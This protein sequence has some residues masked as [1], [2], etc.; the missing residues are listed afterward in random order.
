MNFARF[1]VYVEIIHGLRSPHISMLHGESSATYLVVDSG[2]V[3]GEKNIPEAKGGRG[4]S[5]S[6]KIGPSPLPVAPAFRIAPGIP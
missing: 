4:E 1:R 2:L 6:E 5:T 3:E